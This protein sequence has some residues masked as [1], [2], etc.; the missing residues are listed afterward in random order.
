MIWPDR[1]RQYLTAAE[2]LV[3]AASLILLL[4]LSLIQIVARNFFDTGF[5]HLDVI[6][7][8]LVLCIA[9]MGAAL[10]C[11]N[12]GHIKIDV[13][14]TLLPEKYKNRLTRPLIFFGVVICGL[15]A[16]HALRFWRNEWAFA[17]EAERLEVLFTLM[18]PI[19][20]VVLTLHFLLL[21][22]SG[23][24]AGRDTA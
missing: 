21:G 17:G 13:L 4:A 19:G 2:K 12:N 10:A 23:R 22:L 5:S 20:F 18:I 11:E 7:R 14:A 24:Q 6:T 1:L 16:W 8:H 9:F 3:A 15:F